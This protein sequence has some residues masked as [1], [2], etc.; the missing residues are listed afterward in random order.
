VIRAAQ[1]AVGSGLHLSLF[2]ARASLL[3]AAG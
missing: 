1:D 3:A 2:V